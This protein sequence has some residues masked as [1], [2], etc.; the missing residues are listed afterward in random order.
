VH[1][2]RIRLIVALVLSVTIVS[3]ATTYFDVLAHRHLLRQELEGQTKWMALSILPDI[4]QALRSGDRSELPRLVKMLKGGTGALGLAVYDAQGRLLARSGS[5]QVLNALPQPTVL[6]SLRKNGEITQFGHAGRWEWLETVFPLHNGQQ[7]AGSMVLVADALP[8]RH[9]ADAVW[10]RSFWLIAICVVLITAITAAMVSWFLTRPMS[11]VAERLSRLRTGHS[12]ASEPP[13]VSGVDLFTPIEREVETIAR[14]LH[15]ARAAAAAEAGLR[16]AGESWWTAEKLA[17][18]MRICTGLEPI[19]VVSNREPYMHQRR[20]SEIECV[21]P[22]SG[23]VTALEPVLRACNGVWVAYGSGD[24]DS[25]MVNQLDHVRVPP[26]DPRYTLRRV[27]LSEEEETQYYDGFANEGLWPLCHIAHTR[28]IFR[29]EDWECYQRIN[30]RFA[31]ALLTEMKDHPDP[32]VFVQDYHF[33]L[34]PQIIKAARPDARVAIFWHIPWPNPEAFG[35]CPWQSELLEGLLGAD[36]IGFHTPLHCHNFLSTV[37]RVLESRTSHEHLTTQRRG[38][39]TNV[40]PYPI[41]VAV[42]NAIRRSSEREDAAVREAELIAERQALLSEL[43][44][45]AE[46]LAIGVDRLDY[47][48]GLLERLAALDQLLDRRPWYRERLTLVQIAAP[49]RTRIPSYADLRLRLEEMV[50]RINSRY[51]T[52]DWRPVVLL[53]RQYNHDELGRWYTAADLCLVTSLHDGMNLVAKE[54]VAARDDEDGVLVLS[55]FTGAAGELQD[56]LLV[57]PYDT[58]E[59]AD[60]MHR[61]LQMGR[62]ERRERMHRMRQHV[63]EHNIYLWAADILSDLR[64]LRLDADEGPMTARENQPPVTPIDILEKKTA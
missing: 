24:A 32:V 30:E 25:L 62:T 41:S 31:R 14:S 63:L 26:D 58:A 29:S 11:R 54:F 1:R 55:R 12:K 4:E 34:L 47:T 20:G 52:S 35:I 49:S 3:V 17:A 40:R 59:V 10:R 6:A 38:H 48:K 56:A 7:L 44:V 13:L 51:Q 16:E 23:L 9:E 60:A 43:G 42:E 61:G 27:W 19:F 36:L 33:A 64:E 18:H 21:V 22:P 37:D 5:D 2:F 45:R 57:N 50:E 8:I 46:F 15:A 53:E 28:P 39:V